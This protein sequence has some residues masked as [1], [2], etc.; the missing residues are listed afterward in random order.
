MQQALRAVARAAGQREDAPSWRH[1]SIA[2]RIDF[3]DH[4][5]RIPDLAARHHDYV[6]SIRT[7]LLTFTISLAAALAVAYVLD[8]LSG[9]RSDPIAA[10]A[11]MKN[12][13]PLLAK[14]IIDADSGRIDGLRQWY[15]GAN[16]YQ[17]RQLAGV[18]VLI[19]ATEEITADLRRGWRYRHRLE[20]LQAVST[21]DHDL[22][23]QLDNL[24][25][26]LLVAGNEVTDPKDLQAAIAILP[27]LESALKQRADHGLWDTVGCIRFRS[28]DWQR[29]KEAFDRALAGIT[30]E[31]SKES[32]RIREL[33]RHRRNTAESNRTLPPEVAPAPLPMEWDPQVAPKVRP[34]TP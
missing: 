26:Y 8:P 11:A 22:D 3:L 24:L 19:F 28:G 27:R 14:A 32:N 21:G 25:A 9:A 4:A 18:M 23:L 31:T 34:A 30:G 15:A 6:Q 7:L 33:Y 13:D 29:A 17:R 12:D 5:E 10:L 2:E 20:A 16:G 1:H